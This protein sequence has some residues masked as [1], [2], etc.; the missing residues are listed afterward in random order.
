MNEIELLVEKI[1]NGEEFNSKDIEFIKNNI[2]TFLSREDYVDILYAIGDNDFIKNLVLDRKVNNQQ[3]IATLCIEENDM[4]FFEQIVNDN[5]FTNPIYIAMFLEENRME[6]YALQ[7]I[8][9]WNG[10][11]ETKN[12]IEQLIHMLGDCNDVEFKD[13]L[14]SIYFYLNIQ[15][16]VDLSKVDN[17]VRSIFEKNYIVT[18]DFTVENSKTSMV[19][20]LK[21]ED[22]D[23]Y[24][25]FLAYVFNNFH[26]DS[27]NGGRLVDKIKLFPNFKEQFS[28]DSTA[29]TVFQQEI[30]YFLKN[31]ID[32]SYENNQELFYK[33]VSQSIYDLPMDANNNSS[34]N[35]N[36]SSL[37]FTS[38]AVAINN[39]LYNQS[40]H[41]L[42]NICNND[43][44]KSKN[45]GEDI[46]EKI[47]KLQNLIFSICIWNDLSGKAIVELIKMLNFES[48]EEIQMYNSDRQL[49]KYSTIVL[50]IMRIKEVSCKLSIADSIDLVNS[51]Q[52]IACIDIFIDLIGKI[53]SKLVEKYN[54][55][56]AYAI[57]NTNNPTY[58]LE[59]YENGLINFDYFKAKIYE[60]QKLSQNTI[61][62]KLEDT[63]SNLCEFDKVQLI[64]Q[65]TDKDLIKKYIEESDFSPKYMKTLFFVL[66]DEE[67]VE[68]YIKSN[69]NLD[70]HLK[71]LLLSEVLTDKTMYN[72]FCQHMVSVSS[73]S[74]I[75][76]QKLIDS[77]E[78]KYI[79]I[80]DNNRDVNGILGTYEIYTKEKMI[81]I[82]QKVNGLLE[83][84][85]YSENE[86]IID[87]T[88]IFKKV[89]ESYV[90][91]T[92][93]DEIAVK[94]EMSDNWRRQVSCR[95]F[96]GCILKGLAV[97]SGDAFC[98]KNLLAMRGIKAYTTRGTGKVFEAGHAWNTIRL[99]GIYYKFDGTSERDNTLKTGILS[100]KSIKREHGQN[101]DY[102][103]IYKIR[104]SI[105][106]IIDEEKQNSG[107]KRVDTFEDYE[108]S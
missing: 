72:E 7:I 14:D 101:D 66:D 57:I 49:S 60:L 107:K 38:E 35:A 25:D 106:A 74:E 29:L 58:I 88:I 13:C 83:N 5:I 79:Q 1:Y 91:N 24:E 98:L 87:E 23:T 82:L 21:D 90:R 2:D 42:L 62:A 43:I 15:N 8:K 9:D 86:N 50:A 10:N 46:S 28:T 32:F 36:S 18:L 52:N 4:T 105:D 93:Y 53:D 103:E 102:G 40:C 45:S 81:E 89:Y 100:L 56:L 34:G 85:P 44:M 39:Y 94:D 47:D 19:D 71:Y 51:T 108:H 22:I 99:G 55:D 31:Y 69:E 6:K 95:S 20:K 17:L 73:L 12:E 97:C 16:E 67:Y 48:M 11:D 33:I 70:I 3:L 77:E 96:S 64:L 26:I 104:Q 65:L 78:C 41:N 92:L 27:F 75:D 30:L 59:Q 61:V 54:N 80:C 68:N 76:L 84:I 37:E 63:S